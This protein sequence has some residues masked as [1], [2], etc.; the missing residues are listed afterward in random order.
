MRDDEREDG[1]RA[2]LNLGHTVGH[3]LEL[4]GGYKRFL[5]GE[6]VAL[7]LLEELRFTESLGHTPKEVVAEYTDLAIRLGMTTTVDT[8]TRQAAARHLTADKKRRGSTLNLPTVTARGTSAL[9]RVPL[10]KLEAWLQ[11]G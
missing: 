10:A 8:A 2:L 4:Q 3:A 5:H 11:R 1:N 6:A 7:G 9:V